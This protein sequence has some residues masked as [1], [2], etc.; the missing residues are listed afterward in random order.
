M[1]VGF[2]WFFVCLLFGR[3]GEANEVQFE[4]NDCLKDEDAPSSAS[5]NETFPNIKVQAL[6]VSD[7]GTTQQKH[8][9]DNQR[10]HSPW[11]TDHGL[12]PDI[13]RIAHSQKKYYL[14]APH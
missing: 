1:E 2:V 7:V 8:D 11:R 10:H 12:A 14:W 6:A 3:K 13:S 4:L 9:K 5:P